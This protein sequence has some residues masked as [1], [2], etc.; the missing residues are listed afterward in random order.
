MA[1]SERGGAVRVLAV[2]DHEVFRR[3]ARELV[4]ATEGFTWA[5]AMVSG[6]EAVERSGE[7]CPD[8]ALVDVRMPGMDGLET[9]RRL[10]ALC[11]GLVVVL[12]S[13]G[14]SADVPS[15]IAGSGAAAY[16]RKQALSPR[17]LHQLW[18]E[19]GRSD[20]SEPEQRRRRSSPSPGG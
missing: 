5:G 7:V 10:V 6:G 11:P 2:D 17:A 19:H 8:L 20:V 18:A 16:V 4:E 13:T 1:P 14:E 9:A 12:V 15:G 3:V